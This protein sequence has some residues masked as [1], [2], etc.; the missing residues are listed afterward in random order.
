MVTFLYERGRGRTSW[1]LP[2]QPQTFVGLLAASGAGLHALY[3]FRA[4]AIASAPEPWN[5]DSVDAIVALERGALRVQQ[6]LELLRQLAVRLRGRL[7]CFHPTDV[8]VNR[9]QHVVLEQRVGILR[10]VLLELR[11]PPL[12]RSIRAGPHLC[13]CHWKERGH[14]LAPRSWIELVAL[15][16]SHAS[17][18]EIRQAPIVRAHALVAIMM[19]LF[20]I[21]CC[22][23]VRARVELSTRV[24][25][26][27][28]Q[29]TVELEA[30]FVKAQANVTRA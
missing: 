27:L 13:S 18:R 1:L 24:A 30:V 28:R 9:D 12:R 4:L 22:W 17:V 26:G 2:I 16:V 7:V 11:V 14:S 10:H 6:V 5:L 19:K 20:A 3:T 8:L 29:L 15:R 21:V 23:Q 25:L